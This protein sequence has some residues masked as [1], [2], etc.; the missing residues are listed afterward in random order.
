MLNNSD[1]TCIWV[2]RLA[3]LRLGLVQQVDGLLDEVRFAYSDSNVDLL[4]GKLRKLLQSL[5][6]Q[7][8]APET[9]GEFI[10]SLG[11]EVKVR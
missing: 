2:S 8:V 11:L 1:C 7:Q 5:P 3:S 9:A 4:I 10:K 6:E